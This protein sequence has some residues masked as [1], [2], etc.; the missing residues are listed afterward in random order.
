MEDKAEQDWMRR[1]LRLTSLVLLLA[2]VAMAAGGGWVMADSLQS[3]DIVRN[4]WTYLFIDH[5]IY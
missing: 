5:L 2:S 4:D 3:R 1:S